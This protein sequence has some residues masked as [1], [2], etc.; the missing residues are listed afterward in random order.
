M[1]LFDES[2]EVKSFNGI[3]E[4]SPTMQDMY[5][6]ENQG[7]K[8][9]ETKQE[10]GEQ[11]KSEVIMTLMIPRQEE[12]A[13]AED[14]GEMIWD[15][16]PVHTSSP[17]APSATQVFEVKEVFYFCF[18]LFLFYFNFLL[19]L[20]FFNFHPIHQKF[21]LEIFFEVEVEGII[22]GCFFL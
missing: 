14:N 20:P 10:G 2:D 5:E 17:L 3:K 9:I 13:P 6:E 1:G 18:F 16:A 15:S 8:M 21:S 4:N 12:E 22:W 7:V 11:E 19:V